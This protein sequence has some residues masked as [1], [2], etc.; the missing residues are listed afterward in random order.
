MEPTRPVTLLVMDHA[1]MDG[2]IVSL[3]QFARDNAGDPDLVEDCRCLA[4]GFGF[5]IGGGSAPAYTISR[6]S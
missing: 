3:D 1:T 2:R 6:W 5:T 4:K